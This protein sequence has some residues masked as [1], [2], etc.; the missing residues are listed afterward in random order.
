MKIDEN[1]FVNELK[2]GNHKALDYIY[3]KYVGLTYK[4]VSDVLRN[5]ASY[6]DIEECVSDI[7]VGVWKNA[8]KYRPEVTTFNKWLISVSKYKAIDYLR[9]IQKSENTIE[10]QDH[11]PDI[12]S[13]VDKKIIESNNMDTLISLIKDMK[14]VDKEIFIRRYILNENIIDIAEYLKVPRSVVD[15]RLTR[16]RRSIKNKWIEIM[17]GN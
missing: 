1:N 12:N 11:I 16:G 13:N 3:K 2:K 7:F 5:R 17:G 4:I 10:L 15:N 9:K 6:Q 8:S 14:D